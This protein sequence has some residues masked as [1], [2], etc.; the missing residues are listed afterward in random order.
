MPGRQ[1]LLLT[2]V[3]GLLGRYLLRDLSLIS[4]PLVVLARTSTSAGES[5][6]ERIRTLVEFWQETLKLR[7]PCPVVLSGDLRHASL[8]LSAADRAWLARR[9]RSVVHSAANVSFRENEV[10]EPWLTNT[11]GTRHLLAVCGELGITDFH[12]VS[13]AFVCGNRSGPI[14]EDHCDV[15]PHFHSIYEQSKHEAEQI[16]R[17]TFD[18]H[19]TIY[20]PSVIVGDRR[21]GYTSTYHG[22]YRF[23]DA[24]V[25][26]SRS[27]SPT[28]GSQRRRL[29]LRLPFRDHETR[30]LVPVDW[31]SEAIVRIL[32]QP[33]CHGRTYHLTANLPTLIT[34]IQAVAEAELGLDGI[35]LVGPSE[36][37]DATPLERAFLEA[38]R[39]YWP[40][41]GGD[42]EFNDRNTRA[43]IPRFPAP[44]VDRAMLVRLMRFA[45]AHNWGRRRR[46]AETHQAFDC[47]DYLEHYFPAAAEQSSLA[48]LPIAMT[49]GFVVDGPGG[50][51][52]IC[53][54]DS[55]RVKQ[56]TRAT[57][58]GADVVYRT[59]VLTF[60]A[61]AGGKESPQSAFFDR[62][63]EIAGCVEKGL[64]LA[65]LFGQFVREFPYRPVAEVRHAAPCAG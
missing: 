5:A 57:T 61:V 48:R 24:A 27:S 45:V 17:A 14:L 52:W 9:C 18:V 35:K 51:E 38:V 13:T 43:A 36:L 29:P 55:G 6:D 59:D 42:P 28:K 32:Q 21:T 7:L 12:H 34:D 54:V 25:R 44:R 64:K 65:V 26:L 8:G 22:F 30:N 15:V 3:T 11:V 2:G 41:L 40:Y 31:V 33:A 58:R 1:H 49:L 39:D 20:R 10:G 37:L 62:R 56:M 50:G 46:K 16:I 4:I 47:G 60:A 19:A 63:I 23:L 53:R